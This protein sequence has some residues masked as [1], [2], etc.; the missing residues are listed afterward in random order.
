MQRL[1]F[2]ITVFAALLGNINSGRSS[3][4][5]LTSSQASDYLTLTSYFS[6]ISRLSLKSKLCYDGQSV[7]PYVLASSASGAQDQISVV[8]R[9][10]R[11]CSCGALSLTRGRV[12]HLQLPLVLASAVIF[13]AV[14]ISS[15]CNL[16]LQFYMSAFCIVVKSPVPYRHLLYSDQYLHIP[17]D[18]VKS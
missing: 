3:A 15:T 9:Q 14:K 1:V 10:L 11:V 4:P 8:V 13:T 6:V 2:S 5:W 16:Y 12:Y 17:I 7:G 18:N